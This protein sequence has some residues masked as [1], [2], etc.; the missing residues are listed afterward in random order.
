MAFFTLDLRLE[1]DVIQESNGISLDHELHVDSTYLI[2]FVLTHWENQKTDRFLTLVKLYF[3][4]PF[5]NLGKAREELKKY[6]DFRTHP[7]ADHILLAFKLS[8]FCVSEM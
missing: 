6:P 7:Q 5:H 3:C 1:D 8:T 2:A 4:N